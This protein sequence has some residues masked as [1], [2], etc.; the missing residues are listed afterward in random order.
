MYLK[1]SYSSM[2]MD[3]KR[4]LL[5]FITLLVFSGTCVITC[6]AE[7]ASS[8][9]KVIIGAMPFNEQY[10]LAE[11]AGQ[12]L[13]NAGYTYEINSGLNNAML[14]QGI[15]KGQIDLYIDYTSAIPT[16]F[17]EQKALKNLDPDSVT[18][19]VKEMVIADGVGWGDKIGF[20]NDYQMA[21][22]DTF[23]R[24]KGVENL[25]DLALNAKDMVLGS[26]LV[27]HLDEI[28]G[29]PNLEKTYGYSFR[30]VKPMEPTLMFEAIK[31]N[32][33]DIIPASSTD[34]RIDLFNLTTLND[35]KAALAPYDS[36]LLITKTREDDTA[37]MDAIS[38]M[39]NLID[40]K[41]MRSLNKMF[42]IDKKDAREI[43]NEFLTEQGLI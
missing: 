26:D 33:V 1:I 41:T 39:Q 3:F 5:V 7:E 14:Y 28:Y 2:S 29:L 12:L 23:A 20:R 13:E 37:F 27:F 8:G 21:V 10:I 22:K 19:E 35:D 32:Q 6:T 9:K 42:D 11:I 24:E 34:S 43:A 31:N 25:S 16:Y 36:I 30:E 40:T 15:K 17:E 38:N 18:A 4:V